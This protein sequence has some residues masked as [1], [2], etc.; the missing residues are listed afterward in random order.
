MKHV[1]QRVQGGPLIVLLIALLAAV[2][3]GFLA[4]QPTVQADPLGQGGPEDHTGQSCAECHVDYEAAWATGAHSVAFTRESFQE[5][6]TEFENDPECLQC[7]TTNYV[8][9][10]HTI[11]AE[12][13][14]CEAC[15][16]ENPANHP[17][18]EFV[19]NRAP[20][21]CRN[22]HTGTFAEW[23]RSQHF[24]TEDMG[25]V[26]CATCHNPHGQT[27]R[28]ETVDELCLNCHESAP[29]TY[30]HLTHNEVDFGD[31]EVTCASCHMFRQQGLGDG[32]NDDVVGHNIPDHT[33][34]VETVPCTTCHEDLSG[35]GDF[36]ALVD[37]NTEI[38]EERDALR[39]EVSTLQN[40]LATI[41]A[42]PEVDSTAI[43][44]TQGLIVG[45][46]IGITITWV[47]IR[48]ESGSKDNNNRKSRS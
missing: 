37:V 20:S 2:A 38:A 39:E 8:E 21:A 15:H 32:T 13:V 6:W 3:Y 30:V 22:C 7:H 48:R 28:F 36:P 25:A 11:T 35:T 9:A 43:R 17:P 41:E 16:G 47:L 44:L 12:N 10:T 5:V 40:E 1:W 33:M 26:G 23:R 14:T 27:L 42:E 4:E 29:N 24:F 19:V 45:L 46:G 31:I 34:D 18:A